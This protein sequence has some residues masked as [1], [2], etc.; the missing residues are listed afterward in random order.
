[1]G[2]LLGISPL[3]NLK[4]SLL[5]S[6]ILILAQV[7]A[8]RFL[9]GHLPAFSPGT[10]IGE[11][12]FGRFNYLLSA[13]L[14]RARLLKIRSLECRKSYSVDVKA[15]IEQATIASTV[16]SESASIEPTALTSTIEPILTGPVKEF[17]IDGSLANPSIFMATVIEN[18]HLALGTSWPATIAI[19]T[20]GLRAALFPFTAIQTRGSV[21]T[22]NL[23]PEMDKLRTESMAA[24]QSGQTDLAKKKMLE[25]SALMKSNG[26]GIGRLLGLGIFPV[27]FFMATFFALQR[28]AGQ[29]IPSMVDG[30]MLWFQN[31]CAADPYY[32][33]PIITTATLLSSLEVIHTYRNNFTHS[34]RLLVS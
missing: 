29:P 11:M 27:P 24:R 6:Q 23:K 32:I 21:K 7:P 22:Q 13:R 33:L 15:P 31:L 9:H 34:F 5:L 20:L 14:S 3:P 28:M 26:I 8:D 1:M 17:L 18:V 16:L 25:L 2:V 10:E 19:F 30:G 12:S 4:S